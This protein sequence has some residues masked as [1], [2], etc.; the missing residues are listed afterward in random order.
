M[1]RNAPLYSGQSVI[2]V[3]V[4]C[5]ASEHCV[6]DVDVN[7]VSDPQERNNFASRLLRRRRRLIVLGDNVFLSC[8]TGRDAGFI[9]VLESGSEEV[10]EGSVT[11]SAVR[12]VS[13]CVGCSVA[14]C[15]ISVGV[16]S[17]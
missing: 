6:C 3:S 7:C 13:S 9:V 1:C 11:L 17:S 2:G 12:D 10:T 5:G 15:G 8:S 16:N 14:S 4:A